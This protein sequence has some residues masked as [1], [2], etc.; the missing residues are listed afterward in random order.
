M[1]ENIQYVIII[2]ITVEIWYWVL[3]CVG[4]Q[5]RKKIMKAPE[6]LQG[7]VER[8]IFSTSIGGSLSQHER[9]KEHPETG[10]MTSF[11]YS[12]FGD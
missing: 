6:N 5:F 12:N 9:D 8:V 1:F 2:I 4:F 7:P 10:D 3:D 11:G